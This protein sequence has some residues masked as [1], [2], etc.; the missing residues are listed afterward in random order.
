ME[1]EKLT[2]PS[3]RQKHY[4]YFPKFNLDILFSI[5]IPVYNS[6]KYLS[7][8]IQSILNQKYNNLEIIL[9]DDCSTDNSITISKSFAKKYKNIKIIYNK[10]NE[11]VS[12]CRNKGIRNA[13]GKYIF[14]L[15]SDDYLIDNGLKKLANFV[16]NNSGNNLI[17]FTHYIMKVGN[18]FTKSKNIFFRNLLDVK[19]N[20]LFKFYN[21]NFCHQHCWNYVFER[22]FII[23][24]RLQ[25]IS[26]VSIG[27]DRVFVYKS[28][29][30]C[31]KFIFYKE[32]F[33]CYRLGGALS[34]RM[35]FDICVDYLKIIKEM[36]NF[37]IKKKLTKQKKKFMF[38]EIREPLIEIIPRL[39]LISQSEIFQLSKLIQK[40][41][42]VFKLL[43]VITKKKEMYSFIK[44]Y[45]AFDGLINYRN[46]IIEEIK[47][48]AK[49]LKF[50]KIYVFS[51]SIFGI[52]IAD[53]LL[54]DGYSV[55]GFFDNDKRLW[56]SYVLDLKVI[57]P[58]L[59]KKKSKKELP[60]I[61]VI[62]SN[63]QKHI[64]K[65]I[66]VQLKENGL[67]KK[68]IISKNFHAFS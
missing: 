2:Q 59:L 61:S 40:N 63:Q 50:K 23:K 27:E 67:K 13:V 4:R 20:D 56:G 49:Y 37:V 12:A 35:G 28:L 64:V 42:K 33:Y 47:T 29:C 1:K 34:H 55:K 44:K 22:N 57:S 21:N 14:F 6:E 16:Q 10:R 65:N 3:K 53:I 51:K 36:C 45:G 43:E 54:K 19:I 30:S 41:F 26:G 32:P 60:K 31:K 48:L 11:G 46:F 38:N 5:I 8:C 17:I 52:A 58:L 24:Q 15:D 18:K 39:I 66:F 9:I 7:Q 62:I 68:Q 25:F